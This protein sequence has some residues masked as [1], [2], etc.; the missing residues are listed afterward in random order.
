MNIISL[1]DKHVQEVAKT[2]WAD[3]TICPPKF[4]ISILGYQE[5]QKIILTVNHNRLSFSKI[6]FPITDAYYDYDSI[7]QEMEW[8]YNRTM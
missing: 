7:E 5:E 1:L 4:W 8:L 2:K 3:D 6:I